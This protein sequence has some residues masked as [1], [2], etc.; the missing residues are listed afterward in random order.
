MSQLYQ[1]KAVPISEVLDFH[2]GTPGLTSEEIYRRV[3][4]EG[5]RYE[6]LSAATTIEARLG[7][8]PKC[9]LEGKPLK[10]VD[11]KEG[12]LI[13]RIGANAGT[14]TY[15]PKGS[16]ALND[17]AYFLTLKEPQKFDVNIRW[18]VWRYQQEFFEYTTIS[19]YHAWNK[20]RFLAEMQIDIPLRTIQDEIVN[21]Y[22][23][24]ESLHKKI[25]A[26]QSKML[27]IETKQVL[28]NYSHYQAKD[29]PVSEVLQC[30][31]GNTGLT[32][33]AIYRN[34][35][36]NGPRYEVLSSSTEQETRLGTIPICY[37]NGKKL[38]VFEIQEGILV[39]RNGNYAG[40]IT[41]LEKGRYTLTDHAYFL[42][43]SPTC[44]YKVSLKWI[45]AQYRRVFLDYTSNNLGGNNATW[46]KTRFF[47]NVKIDIP[48]YEEQSGLVESYDRFSQFQSKLDQLNEKIERLQERQLVLAS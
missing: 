28:M 15:I 44:P 13:S 26:M 25:R 23:Q 2:S 42:S 17:D 8:I 9:Q 19:D 40:T 37:I 33:E 20:T 10:T 18:F 30:H 35:L 11:D 46:N 38:E 43:L 29:Y 32:S 7:T 34:I 3:L 47:E 24:L 41:F 45:I 12:I 39:S 21:R 1:A 16:Y 14:I 48:D 22:A 36:I 6:V 27:R 5:P 4:L 31:G